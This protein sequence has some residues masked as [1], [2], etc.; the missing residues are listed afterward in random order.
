MLS[1]LGI[2]IYGDPAYGT[3][4]IL[5]APFLGAALSGAQRAFN[6]SMSQVRVS[7]E[8]FFGITKSIWA[9]IQWDKKHKILLS[10]VAKMVKVSVLLTNCHTCIKGS[11]EISAFF[12]MIPPTLAEYLGE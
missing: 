7:V 3:N 11:N 10:P 1:T 5:C 4:D 12:E 6:K 2:C 8:W 9:F